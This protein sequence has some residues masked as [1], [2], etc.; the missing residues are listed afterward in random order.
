MKKIRAPGS[1]SNARWMGKLLYACK[2]ALFRCSLD[3]YESEKSLENAQRIAL[4]TAVVFSRRWLSS[5]KLFTAPENLFNFYKEVQ[6][7]ECIDQEIATAARKKLDLH[8]TY[9]SP[10]RIWVAFFSPS[11]SPAEKRGIS[12]RKNR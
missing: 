10:E 4:F 12:D 9:L 6:A 1:T 11:F 2:R 8:L 3:G 7:F 5:D